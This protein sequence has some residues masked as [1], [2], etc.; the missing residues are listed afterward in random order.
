MFFKKFVKLSG[1]PSYILN[2]RSL[3]K[4]ELNFYKQNVNL[5]A[6]EQLKTLKRM[7]GNKEILTHLFPM[8]PFSTRWKRQKILRLSDASKG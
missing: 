2:V 1:P 4:S 7:L 6:A 5:R 8:Q 3:S